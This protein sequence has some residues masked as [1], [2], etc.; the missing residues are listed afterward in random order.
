MRLEETEQKKFSHDI[1][2]G[3]FFMYSGEYVI[4]AGFDLCVCFPC[5]RLSVSQVLAFHCFT[6]ESNS[7][8]QFS[9]SWIFFPSFLNSK[10]KAIQGQSLTTGAVITVLLQH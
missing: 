5:Y 3:N 4:R 9:R 6:L 10:D 1:A 8:N 7:E 2:L